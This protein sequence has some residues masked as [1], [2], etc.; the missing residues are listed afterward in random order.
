MTNAYVS[1]VAYTAVAQWAAATAYSLG[2]Y[3]RQ[4]AAP[5][6]GNE[7]VFKVTT[8][9]TSGGAEPAW[10]LT[11]N[12]TT[13]DGTVTWTQV[14]G[15]EAEQLAG[16]W[17]APHARVDSARS[18]LGLVAGDT[19]FVSS[20]HAETKAAA[21][22]VGSSTVH[23][24]ILSVSRVGASLPPTSA[25]LSAG[26]SIATTGANSISIQHLYAHG[27]TFSAGSGASTAS[28][29]FTASAMRCQLENCALVLANTSASSVIT[30]SGTFKPDVE[31]INT[32][33]TFGAAGQKISMVAADFRWLATAGAILGTAPTTLISFSGGNADRADV[34]ISG[35]DL[36]AITGTLVGASS[37]AGQVLIRDCRLA[38]G[39]AV[40]SSAPATW[41]SVVRVHNCDDSTNGRNYRFTEHSGVGTVSQDIVVRRTGGASDGITSLSHKYE[42]ASGISGSIYRPLCGPWVSKRQNTVGGAVTLTVEIISPQATAPTNALVWM[43]TEA[44]ATSGYPLAARYSTRIA[45]PLHTASTLTASTEA[46]DAG[47]TA[48]AN[49]TAY[50]VGDIRKVASNPGRVFY[51][52]TAG[53]SAGSEPAGYSSAVDG[54]SVTDGTAVFRAMW[55]QKVTQSFT[56]QV[57]GVVR[58][59]IC[60]A[61][62]SA[63]P[64]ATLY[65]DPKLTIA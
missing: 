18:V 19:I 55:R 41:S 57:R 44:L 27:V 49:S 42:N 56:P 23:V 63:S 51:C 20:D 3:V 43:E 36:S 39:V 17:R 12:G 58:A 28:I 8:A 61:F 30:T 26:A 60:T 22:T 48:R 45:S 40:A 35:V 62:A 1:S 5:T 32:T 21:S 7:R 65:A 33:M 54:G 11:N 64:V 59:R 53:T 9:G 24:S 29:T 52:S 13:A 25:D 37:L 10:T 31:L 46:W 6:V 15:Q 34:T 50:S 4:L 38:S 14:A 16:N 47:V 2:Q